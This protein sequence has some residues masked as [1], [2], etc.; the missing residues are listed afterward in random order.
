MVESIEHRFDYAFAEFAWAV[1]SEFLLGHGAGKPHA[2][3]LRDAIVEAALAVFETMETPGSIA[4]T[5]A[6]VP[7]A[8]AA[9]PY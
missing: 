9:T 5:A 2:E 7:G 6:S 1:F 4:T 8:G 3:A